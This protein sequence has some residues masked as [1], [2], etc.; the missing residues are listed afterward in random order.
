LATKLSIHTY[1]IGYQ[2]G[3]IYFSGIFASSV[4]GRLVKRGG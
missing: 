1:W 4:A 2:V 3:L